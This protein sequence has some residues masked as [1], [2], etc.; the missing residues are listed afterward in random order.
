MFISSQQG[1][2][3]Q[4]ENLQGS[5]EPFKV[6]MEIYTKGDL[7]RAEVTAETTFSFLILVALNFVLCLDFICSGEKKIL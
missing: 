2:D 3:Q 1:L 6:Q 4:I 5:S 7:V